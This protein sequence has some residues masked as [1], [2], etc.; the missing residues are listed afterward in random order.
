MTQPTQPKIQIFDEYAIPF[1]H[2][3]V[4]LNTE[5]LEGVINYLYPDVGS[6]SDGTDQTFHVSYRI[7][8]GRIKNDDK[9][10]IFGICMRETSS[11]AP[12]NC[13]NAKYD[14]VPYIFL[15]N[16]SKLSFWRTDV[17]NYGFNKQDLKTKVIFSNDGCFNILGCLGFTSQTS[18][19]IPY[20]SS[21]LVG[22]YEDIIK[23]QK[24]TTFEVEGLTSTI[25]YKQHAT[26]GQSGLVNTKRTRTLKRTNKK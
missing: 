9:F 21:L 11:S 5:F 3:S 18:A 6:F 10:L 15:C 20:K 26:S 12:S 14:T 22:K 25:I 23:D 13:A 8:A 4:E 7:T 1:S 2:E 17:E 24:S 19:R 16:D